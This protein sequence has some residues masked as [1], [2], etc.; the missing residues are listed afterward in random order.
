MSIICILNKQYSVKI[1]PGLADIRAH[2]FFGM[3]KANT[4]V[5]NPI[6]LSNILLAES[7]L[8][9]HRTAAQSH[10]TLCTAVG[11]V[12]KH[13]FFHLFR[14][15]MRFIYNQTGCC[16]ISSRLPFSQKVGS[17]EVLSNL[18]CSMIPQHS[19]E[20]ATTLFSSVDARLIVGKEVAS[21]QQSPHLVRF[22]TYA[23]S[24]SKSVFQSH[25]CLYLPIL[26]VL[27]LKQNVSSSL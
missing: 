21:K 24:I 19:K 7:V 6:G 1:F 25:I 22:K 13:T 16:I 12:T 18:G 3:I 23:A 26:S 10:R 27:L 14:K 4:E 17:F 15:K 8:L 20:R 2:T 11:R 9:L 5:L